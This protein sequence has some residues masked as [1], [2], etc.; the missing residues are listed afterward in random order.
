MALPPWVCRRDAGKKP[1]RRAGLREM[2]AMMFGYGGSWPFWEVG[3]M[4]IGIIAFWGLV[5]WGIYTLVTSLT[6]KQDSKPDGV[7]ATRI[8]DERLA[9]GEID[10]AEYRHL[11]DAMTAGQTG[12]PSGTS[13][14]R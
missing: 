1:A 13:S 4:W 5:I 14:R 10:A 6:R 12:S 9:R 8:L 7:P 3:L 11:K 2:A